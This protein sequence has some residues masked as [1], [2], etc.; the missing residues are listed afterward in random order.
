MSV[1]IHGYT[2]DD[3]VVM[4]VDSLRAVLHERTHH[5]I[6]VQLYRIIKGKMKK[7]KNFGSQARVLLDV[8][9]ERELPTDTPDLQWCVKLIEVA[10]KLNASLP[11]KLKTE[12]PGSFSNME[13]ETVRKLL[14]GRR[15]IRQ[16]TDM[17]V[18]DE[19]LREIMYAGL[20]APQ[21]CNVGSTRFIVLRSPEEWRLVRS[22]IPIE[23]GVMILICQDLRVYKTLR[24]DQ[25]VP[26]N[27]Y[28]DAAAA[29]DHMCLMAHALGL[30]AC[31][32]T[33]GEKTQKSIRDLFDLPE[34]FITRCHLI[35]GW[36]D[37]APIKSQRMSLND[38]IIEKTN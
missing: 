9:R 7:P 36:P 12:L 20:M 35:I 23:N 6:E 15:S 26:Q 32:L 18:S 29:A 5:T 38:T 34:T 2:R 37:E 33:H 3:L 1:K 28:Y 25:F 14:Y 24:F 13:M 8:W 22:D 21:G 27:I 11:V 10:E 19:M 17:P 4:D 16:F 31:W 30:G